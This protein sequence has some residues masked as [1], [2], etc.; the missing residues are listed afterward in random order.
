MSCK[1]RLYLKTERLEIRGKRRED[2]WGNGDEVVK[3]EE[4]ER[5]TSKLD[6]LVGGHAGELNQ[7]DKELLEI[8]ARQTELMNAPEQKKPQCI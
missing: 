2:E 5:Y 1:D 8:Q 4:Q 7:L 3:E 6:T